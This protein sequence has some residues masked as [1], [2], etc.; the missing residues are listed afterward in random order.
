MYGCQTQILLLQWNFYPDQNGLFNPILLSAGYSWKSKDLDN[1]VQI[2]NVSRQHWVCDSNINCIP[3]TVDVLDSIRGFSKNSTSLKNQNTYK[4]LQL[5][6]C[7]CSNS[8]RCKWLQ[9]LCYSICSISVIR[10]HDMETYD[11][12]KMRNHLHKCFSAGHLQKRGTKCFIWR[13]SENTGP[14]GTFFAEIFGPGGP[15]VGD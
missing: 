13:A 1:F 7:W 12:N 8:D 9:P 10:D 2:I 3:H 5:R 6:L 4:Q 11:Q 14:P 15:F